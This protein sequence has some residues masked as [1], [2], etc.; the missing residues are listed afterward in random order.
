MLTGGSRALC[1]PRVSRTQAKVMSAFLVSGF[2]ISVVISAMC[3]L[4][5]LRTPRQFEEPKES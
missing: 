5:S 1:P 2:M 3:C 4:G